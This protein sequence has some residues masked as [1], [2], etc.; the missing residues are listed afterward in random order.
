M[1]S[2]STATIV[3]ANQHNI[4]TRDLI[5]PNNPNNH[6]FNMQ[7]K[8]SS[9]QDPKYWAEGMTIIEPMKLFNIMMKVNS[10]RYPAVSD[11]NYL[12]LL[13]IEASLVL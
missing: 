2:S 7:E 1:T 9:V 6:G 13:G 11:A 4:A 3:G 10:D 5:N 12:L 8:V